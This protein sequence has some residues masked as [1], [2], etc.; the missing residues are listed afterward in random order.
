MNDGGL[1]LILVSQPLI[2]IPIT[3]PLMPLHTSYPSFYPPESGG[4][5]EADDSLT[6][7]HMIDTFSGASLDLIQGGVCVELYQNLVQIKASSARVSLASHLPAFHFGLSFTW[8]CL[9]E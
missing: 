6:L 4:T 2:S 3:P 8:L 5:E 9:S 1:V 7:H